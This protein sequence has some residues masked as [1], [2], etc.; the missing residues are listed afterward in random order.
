MSSQIRCGPSLPTLIFL[1]QITCVTPSSSHDLCGVEKETTLWERVE[2]E[3]TANGV[4]KFSSRIGLTNKLKARLGFVPI[5]LKPDLWR[6]CCRGEGTTGGIFI[7][8]QRCL[9]DNSRGLINQNWNFYDNNF[10]LAIS[11]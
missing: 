2:K 6:P 5:P 3:G 11:G 7:D 8:E 10:W 1:R 4:T 9:S